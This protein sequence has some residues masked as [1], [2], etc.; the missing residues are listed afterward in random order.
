[1]A[2]ST[3]KYNRQYERAMRHSYRKAGKNNYKNNVIIVKKGK[4]TS[5]AEGFSEKMILQNTML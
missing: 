5:C 1:M 4:G 2:I 3:R